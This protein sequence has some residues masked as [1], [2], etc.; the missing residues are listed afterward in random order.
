MS[1]FQ[2]KKNA[3]KEKEGNEKP[4]RDQGPCVQIVENGKLDREQENLISDF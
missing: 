2:R 4:P 1:N 3:K